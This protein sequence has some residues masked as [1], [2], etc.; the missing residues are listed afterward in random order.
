MN[1]R[2]IERPDFKA[3]A[4]ITAREGRRRALSL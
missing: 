4:M 1:A 2:S 3:V